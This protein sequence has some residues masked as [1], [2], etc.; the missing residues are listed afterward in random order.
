MDL[1]VKRKGDAVLR[2]AEG[3]DFLQFTWF[4]TTEVVA[5]ESQHTE[6]AVAKGLLQFLQAFVLGGETATTGHIDNQKNLAGQIA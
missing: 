5:G 6:A 2:A 1:G 3:F 4:L